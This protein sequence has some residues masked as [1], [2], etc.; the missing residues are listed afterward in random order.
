MWR[1]R[2]TTSPRSRADWSPITSDVRPNSERQQWGA[3]GLLL[4]RLC[5]PLQAEWNQKVAR[6]ERDP[7]RLAS[8]RRPPSPDSTAP[9][10]RALARYL[11]KPLVAVPLLWQPGTEPHQSPHGRFLMAGIIVKTRP[12]GRRLRHIRHLNGPIAQFPIHSG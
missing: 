7:Q 11:T 8:G 6:Q 12:V 2:A 10:L 1:Q 3:S 9:R 5:K 4:Q